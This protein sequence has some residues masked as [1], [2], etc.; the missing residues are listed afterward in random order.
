MWDSGRRA[1]GALMGKERAKSVNL[2]RRRRKRKPRKTA[3]WANKVQVRAGLDVV[4]VIN[5][6]FE[7]F[8]SVTSI[9][10]TSQTVAGDRLEVVEWKGLRIVFKSGQNG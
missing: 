9:T 10:K 3:R 1:G 5:V 8:W 2:Q 6:I 7:A 4:D